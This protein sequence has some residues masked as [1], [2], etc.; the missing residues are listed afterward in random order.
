MAIRVDDIVSRLGG[1]LLGPGDTLIR[2][3]APLDSAGPDEI[4][5]LANPKYRKQLD[6]TAAAAVIVG[7]GLTPPAGKS[8]I[9][10]DA[11]YLYFARVAQL[12]HPEPPPDPGVDPR[13]SVSSEIPASVRVE[14][15]ACIDA[16][17]VLGED[18]VI[19]AGSVV[20]RGCRI[21]AGTRLS[22]NVTLYPDCVIGARC[23]IHSGA[24]IGAD[25]FG[26]ARERDGRWVKIPQTGRVV[27]GDDVEIGANTTIDRGAMDDTVIGDGV[28]LDNQIQIAH[29]VTIGAMTAVAG[30]V[31]IAGSTRIGARCMIGGQAGIIGHLEIADDVMVS[32]G[33]LVTKSIRKAGV[34][35]ANLPLQ[36]HGDWVREFSHLRHLDSMAAR[37]RELEKRLDKGEASS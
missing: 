13:A 34:Y 36:A 12:L 23:R 29:N 10:S 32:A 2:A 6:S 11:P 37:I 8:Y 9:V 30:C 26:Y 3:L 19:G 31:G 17:V 24:V 25:G 21:G 33:T 1:E 16:S 7:A 20:G 35:T 18:V 28:K 4:S 5:F 22:A 15:G 14:A 27:I